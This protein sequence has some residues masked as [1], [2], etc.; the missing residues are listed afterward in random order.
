MNE[1]ET[2][3]EHIDPRLKRRGGVSS[4]AVASGQSTPSPWVGSRTARN[5]PN[6][7]LGE[8]DPID[9][10]VRRVAVTSVTQDLAYE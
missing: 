4:R 10:P 2:R 7:G 6:R 9:E 5:G 1:A 3:V 8:R